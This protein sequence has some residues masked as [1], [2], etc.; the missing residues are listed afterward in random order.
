[1]QMQNQKENHQAVIS[2]VFEYNIVNATGPA[3]LL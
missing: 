3:I 1:M 2:V